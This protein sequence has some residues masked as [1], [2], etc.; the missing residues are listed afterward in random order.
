MGRK[1]VGQSCLFVDISSSQVIKDIGTPL[2]LNVRSETSEGIFIDEVY[3][4]ALI[5]QLE[6]Q[7]TFI[8]DMIL[9]SLSK[10]VENSHKINVLNGS[11]SN[12]Q[13]VIG[14]DFDQYIKDHVKHG[15]IFRTNETFDGEDKVTEK[16]EFVTKDHRSD[17][18][19]EQKNNEIEELKQQVARLSKAYSELSEMV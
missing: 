16:S 3:T 17:E 13:S 14:N 15:S 11:A 9:P 18:L 8:A 4:I 5:E 12:S 7:K 2:G 6:T 1:K 10:V 19:L